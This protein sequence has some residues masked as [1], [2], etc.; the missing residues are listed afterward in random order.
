MR[1]MTRCSV[2][3]NSRFFI[4]VGKRLSSLNR[5]FTAINIRF[6]ENIISLVSRSG[7]RWI[8]FRLVGIGRLR[9]NLWYG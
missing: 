1:L 4:L 7:F 9:V 5:L 2:W 3:V 6:G 8:R